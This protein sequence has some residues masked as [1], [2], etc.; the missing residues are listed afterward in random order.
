MV[1]VAVL[2]LAILMAKLAVLV[3]NEMGTVAAMVAM[4]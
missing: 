2:A 1:Q 4:E 3:R